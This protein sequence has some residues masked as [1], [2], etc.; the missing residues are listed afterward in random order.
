MKTETFN[1]EVYKLNSTKENDIRKIESNR[2][3]SN[4]E[5]MEQ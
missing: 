5:K 4:N 1:I 3:R 2:R